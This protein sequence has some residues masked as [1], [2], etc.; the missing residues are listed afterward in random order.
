M[1]RRAVAGSSSAA[2]DPRDAR[3]LTVH[4]EGSNM[5]SYTGTDQV[6]PFR[7]AGDT[8]FLGIP[9]QYPATLLRVR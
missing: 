8:L 5:P 2:P 1:I 3:V 4:V 7:L 6:R 9:G